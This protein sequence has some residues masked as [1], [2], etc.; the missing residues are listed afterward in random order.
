MSGDKAIRKMPRAAVGR[1]L[2]ASGLECFLL[3]AIVVGLSLAAPFT[4]FLL[5]LLVPLFAVLWLVKDLKGGEFSLSKRL[6]EFRV[7]DLSTGEIASTT[8]SLLRNSYYFV[9]ILLSAVPIV[10]WATLSLV[11]LL[12]MIDVMIMVLSP[13]NRRV[14]DLIANTQVVPI[15][16]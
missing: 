1:R 6:G 11:A 4:G 5:E 9:L 16:S 8:Q 2:A 7:V 13:H 14:G 12:M 15:R 3:F 10:E